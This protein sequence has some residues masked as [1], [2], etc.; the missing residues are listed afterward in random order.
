[1]IML[2]RAGI[3]SS[4]AINTTEKEGKTR[5]GIITEKVILNTRNN[6][7]IAFIKVRKFKLIKKASKIKQNEKWTKLGFAKFSL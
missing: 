4:N 7:L 2:P 3:I 6:I 5:E 1:M